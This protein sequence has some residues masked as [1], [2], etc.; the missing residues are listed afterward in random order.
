[1]SSWMGLN[2]VALATLLI[3]ACA[4]EKEPAEGEDTAAAADAD[5]T[6]P[7]DENADD[8]EEPAVTAAALTLTPD[9]S[10]LPAVLEVPLIDGVAYA[11]PDEEGLLR[12][13]LFS[14]SNPGCDDGEWL[15][16]G[17]RQVG[18]FAFVEVGPTAFD[19]S[20][21]ADVSWGTGPN[22]GTAYLAGEGAFSLSAATADGLNVGDRLEGTVELLNVASGSA[23]RGSMAVTWCGTLGESPPPD[24]L[25][26]EGPGG[27]GRGAWPFG[28]W[29]TGRAG[30]VGPRLPR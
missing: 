28:R 18:G 19:G 2:A 13:A 17:V 15:R 7:S 24:A 10:D 25:L 8:T 29:A 6:G 4:P 30:S 27:A 3:G 14:W 12:V 9:D 20:L 5:D 16:T 11:N 22:A 1:M 23:V 21:E 26:Y